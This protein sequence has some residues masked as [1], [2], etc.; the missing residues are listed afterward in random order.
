VSR[1]RIW[2]VACALIGLLWTRALAAQGEPRNVLVTEF[3]GEEGDATR[4]AVLRALG[5]K[6]KKVRLV[7]LDHAFD[8]AADL[9]A[10]LTGRAGLSKV[11]R[12]LGLSLIV[13]GSVVEKKRESVATLKIYDGTGELVKVHQVRE[14]SAPALPR[15][16][17]T[18]TWRVVRTLLRKRSERPASA[19][20][21]VAPF[22]GNESPLVRKWVAQAL[23]QETGVQL[24]SEKELP[25]AEPIAADALSD[26]V[27]RMA[28]SVNAAV[29][30]AGDVRKRAGLHQARV[31]LLNG[32]D[33]E[34][35]GHFE[36]EGR[37]LFGVKA[38]LDRTLRHD[39]RPALALSR[40][41]ELPRERIPDGEA[42]EAD[43]P[44]PSA[45]ERTPERQRE[46]RTPFAAILTG[47]VFGRHFH[48]VEPG[49]G[50]LRPYDLGAASAAGIRARWYP[51]AHFGDG[52]ASH[53][54]AF[55]RY[56]RAL[57]ARSRGANG[58]IVESRAENW[59]AAALGRLLLGAHSATA[60]LGYGQDAFVVGDT[61][62]GAVPGVKYSF[63]RAGAELALGF[64]RL[65]L[66]AG[67]GFRFLTGVGELGSSAWFPRA[68][69]LGTDF[70]LGAGY[71]VFDSLS[72]AL[73]LEYRRY[74]LR[75][76]SEK[77]DARV[78]A[79]A[80]DELPSAWF[81]LAWAP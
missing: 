37:G 36:F 31:R 47:G 34:E 28:Q 30:V 41:P 15:R 2:I 71:E 66:G 53:F 73:G 5:S 49:A 77:G 24:V 45:A 27:V 56:E 39:V 18:E 68:G 13:T 32:A 14:K 4:G 6:K 10:N 44:A 46:G 59:Q 35:L 72:L 74:A 76:E 42:P 43:T 54:G 17:E 16:V 52:A 81:G 3:S 12:V 58:D 48:Y 40:A 79:G 21:M 1:T 29:I 80:N 69:G 60:A 22:E 62:S 25:D 7:A 63:L 23:K 65:Q 11:S 57:F 51:G 26:S 19:R 20:V 75:F 50:G 9:E 61:A 67:A 38:K 70:E 55:G 64:G 78:A 33:G 8:V